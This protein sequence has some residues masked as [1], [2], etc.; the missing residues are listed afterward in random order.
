M[1]L[2]K[3]N[4]DLEKLFMLGGRLEMSD[5]EEI[6]KINNEKM[7]IIVETLTQVGALNT[8]IKLNR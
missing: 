7:A 5:R 1:D 3:L 8:I 4:D 2:N 6:V